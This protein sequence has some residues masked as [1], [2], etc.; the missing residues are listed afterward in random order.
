[1]ALPRRRHPRLRRGALHPVALV[2]APPVGVARVVEAA[3]RVAGRDGPAALTLDL[4]VD[5]LAVSRLTRLVTHDRLTRHPRVAVFK[6]AYMEQDGG[7]FPGWWD[8]HDDAWWEDRVTDDGDPPLEAAFIV[9]PWC[10]GMW[11]GLGVSVARVVA[12]R[13]WR[14]VAR[15]LALSELTGR[16][17]ELE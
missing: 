16:L 17:A 1:M 11:I 9:C 3:G 7:P 14:W 12:P 13:S 10:V 4:T 6:Q 2:A 5:A 15:A 8:A